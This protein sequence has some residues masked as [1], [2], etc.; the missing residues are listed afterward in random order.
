MK[1]E[2]MESYRK[3][4]YELPKKMKIWKLYGKGLENF[5]R[6][7]MPEEVVI[8]SFADDQ[9][10]VRIDAVGIC[11]SDVKLINAGSDHPRIMGRNLVE[12]PVTP[13][14]EVSLTVVGV[15]DKLERKYKVGDRFIVQADITYKGK[16][17]AYGYAMT[18]AMAQYGVIGEEILEGDEGCYLIKVKPETGYAEAALAEPWACVVAS[19]NIEH[20]KKIK[21]DGIILFMGGGENRDSYEI[22][23]GMEPQHYPAKVLAY[24]VPETL[25]SLLLEKTDSWGATLI[26][27]EDLEGLYRKETGGNGFDDIVLLGAGDNER[28]ALGAKY[29][30]KGG[31]LNIVAKEVNREKIEVDVGRV[32]YEDL[33]IIGNDSDDLSSAYRSPYRSD[34]KKG[35]SAW[36]VGGAGPMGQMHLQRAV[37]ME[38]GPSK[39]IITDL[40]GGRLSVIHD[41]LGQKA[42][43]KGIRFVLHNPKDFSSEDEFYKQMEIESDGRGFDDIVVLVPVP[44]VIGRSADYLGEGGL[45]NIFAGVPVGTIADLDLSGVYS[46]NHR[47]IGMSGSGIE[48]LKLTLSQAESKALL[49]NYSVAAIGGMKAIWQG[50]DGVKNG[51]FPGKTVIYPQIEDLELTAIT[52]L[53]GS[54]PEVGKKMD[55]GSIWTVDAEEELLNKK[56]KNKG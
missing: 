10:L 1:D 43:D 14:H 24:D 17:I 7:A 20:R 39:I 47:Y 48:D 15:G 4:E 23:E 44:G 27:G 25:R 52:D 32:H 31:I 30:A 28:T 56:I 35:G 2:K 42:A 37:D 53:P 11:F 34:L 21:K 36:F 26:E 12:N 8:P 40:D 50:V 18:G 5:G 41:R 55:K 9:L 6:S 33:F 29:L 16:G 51:R 54:E 13:G 49:T 45:M 46:K 3:V 22:V 38:G 19:Y